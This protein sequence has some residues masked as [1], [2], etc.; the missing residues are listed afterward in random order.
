MKSSPAT[1]MKYIVVLQNCTKTFDFKVEAI[2]YVEYLKSVGNTD[3]R[4]YQAFPIENYG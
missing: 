1:N 2:E 3:F 4:F